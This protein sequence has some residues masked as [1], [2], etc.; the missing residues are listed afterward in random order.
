MGVKVTFNKDAMKDLPL[1]IACP[2]E[3]CDAEVSFK[4][5]DA[6]QEKTVDCPKCGTHIN[7]T[8]KK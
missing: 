5:R 1:T 6:Q 2:N 7:L 4:L 3:E 8:T